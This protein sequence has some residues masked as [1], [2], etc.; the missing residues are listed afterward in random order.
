MHHPLKTLY[1]LCS[2]VTLRHPVCYK[3]VTWR[4][5]QTQV[6]AARCY[7]IIAA[8]AAASEL[9]QTH[10]VH[11]SH[12][13]RFLFMTSFNSAHVLTTRMLTGRF[14]GRA[15]EHAWSCLLDDWLFTCQG[16]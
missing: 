3:E 14:N 16:M 13:V 12:R 1:V 2:H 15:G 10:K 6:V 4:K 5:T 7:V 11:T 9:G 8:A